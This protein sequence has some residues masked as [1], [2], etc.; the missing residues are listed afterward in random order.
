MYGH[1]HLASTATGAT[2]LPL[3]YSTAYRLWWVVLVLT[4]IAAALALWRLTPRKTK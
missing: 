2:A 1:Y 4:L 3:L